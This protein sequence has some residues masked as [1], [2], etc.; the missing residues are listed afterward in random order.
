MNVYRHGDVLIAP[1]DTIPEEAFK[2]SHL[3]LAR[4]ELTGHTHRFETLGRAELYELSGVLYLHV[5]D[6]PGKV[7][8]E[9]HKAIDLMPGK[10]RVWR[11]REFD[12]STASRIIE[13]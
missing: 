1:V 5:V 11:Q 6:E 3:V 13:D 8:H 9:E 7:V 2:L 12:P 10:Y 4:G